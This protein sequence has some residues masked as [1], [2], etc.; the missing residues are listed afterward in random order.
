MTLLPLLG[1]LN[2]TPS[3]RELG[4]VTDTQRGGGGF[5]IRAY[6]GLSAPVRGVAAGET[7]IVLLIS[8]V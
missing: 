1:H 4:C 8:P 6:V 2:H 5:G 7:V 3:Q